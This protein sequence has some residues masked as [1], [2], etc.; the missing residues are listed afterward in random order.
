M[1]SRRLTELWAPP[2]GY[3]LASAVATTYELQADFLEEDLLPV[4]L[5]LRLPPARGREFRLELEHALQDTEVSV[6]FHPGRY[7]PGLRRSPRI[8]LLPLPEGRYPKL[9][10]KLAL[11]RFVTPASPEVENQIVRLVVGSAN[12]TNLGYRS[13][14][15]VCASIDDGP[16]ASLEAMTAVRDAAAW[17]QGLVGRTTD[18]IARQFRD[19]NAAFSSRPA[20]RQDT[21][22][23]FV[24]L[25][26]DKG[27]P[28]LATSGERVTRV[29]I[30]S[31]FW[32]SGDD[33]SDV[34]TALRR[35]C[36]GRW[37][38]VRLIG[39]ADI[40]DRGLARPVIPA[41]LVRALL[42]AGARVEVA[43]ADPGHGCTTGDDED[44]G[45]FDSMSERQGPHVEARRS[46]HAKALLV[47][48]DHG[49]RLAIGSFNFTRKG[50][51]LID[52]GNLEAGLLWALPG[53]GAACL[54]SLLSFAIDWR[55]VTQA[56]ELFVVEPSTYEVN[57]ADGWPS[58]ILALRAKRDELLVDGDAATW[59]RDVVIRMRD[60]R[61][62]LL[63]REEWFDPWTVHPPSNSS[64]VFSVSM[65]LRASWLERSAAPEGN[66]WPALPDL[67][68]EEIGRAS[69][70]ERV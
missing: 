4:A 45:E 29:T 24:G 22:L 47:E 56:P 35:L 32:P 61:S 44:E 33:L 53:K 38:T 12:L 54:T 26:S 27:F 11:L 23:R 18:K 64:G 6:L 1:T 49:T 13:N 63:N 42:A 19:I 9:H 34:A 62:R 16:G 30:A 46:L 8:D 17:A 28:A 3:R 67:E 43:A 14:I 57:G 58:F 52:S 48:G 68:V 37:E 69:C 70:R 2:Q 20:Q 7:Q 51:G 55:R 50:M 65:P 41:G 15:E 60:I 21:Q 31:P 66:A 40:D 25:P 39:P 5:G 10:A 36:G 59:P